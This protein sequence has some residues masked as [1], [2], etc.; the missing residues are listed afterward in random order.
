MGDSIDR[1]NFY[2]SDDGGADSVRSA[3]PVP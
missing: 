3:A 1:R 2:D